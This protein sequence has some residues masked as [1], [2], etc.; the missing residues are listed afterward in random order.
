MGVLSGHVINN[1]YL[2]KANRIFYFYSS[3]KKP[4]INGLLLLSGK[5]RYSS[6]FV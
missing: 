6:F 3:W 4:K 5:E 2:L 1:F